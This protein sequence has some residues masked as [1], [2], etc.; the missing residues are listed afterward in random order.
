M[1][2]NI[3]RPWKYNAPGLNET[4]KDKSLKDFDVLRIMIANQTQ[5]EIAAKNLIKLMEAEIK[6]LPS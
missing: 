2:E 5:I 1:H 6:L 3:T 4:E